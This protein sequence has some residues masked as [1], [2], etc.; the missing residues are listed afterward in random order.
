M[1]LIICFTLAYLIGSIP[2]AY[3]LGKLYFHQD[4]RQLGSGNIGTT[5]TFRT[6]GFFPGVTVLLL[7]IFKGTLG[8]SLPLFLNVPGKQWM[9]L[10]G[11][12][13]VIG[14]CFPIFLHFKGGKAV[15]TGSG[16]LLAY[17]PPLFLVAAGMFLTL[18]LLTSTVSIAS[19]VVM[20]IFTLIT[21]FIHDYFLML[22]A[23]VVTIIV[24]VRHLPNIKRLAHHQE[25]IVHL[26]LVYYLRKKSHK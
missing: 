10:V 6:F 21:F 12:A 11:I 13:A 26:G 22:A 5:N 18:V 4:I 3:L 20:P 19:L 14:H 25:N 17:N 2:S 8:A 9:L 1:K 7:D 24:Y 23:I 16:I 15:A